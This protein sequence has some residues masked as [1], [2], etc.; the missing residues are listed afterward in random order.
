MEIIY[1]C[2]VRFSFGFSFSHPF[3]I[4]LWLLVGPA[5]ECGG[6][7][8]GRDD[9]AGQAGV[10]V[11]SIFVWCLVYC[12]LYIQVETIEIKLIKLLDCILCV[13]PG[14][15]FAQLTFG[16]DSTTIPT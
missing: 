6:G 11:S 15:A 7:E 2:L 16:S 9:W 1:Q 8:G 3:L 13:G 14:G 4:R 5:V 12:G 10:T